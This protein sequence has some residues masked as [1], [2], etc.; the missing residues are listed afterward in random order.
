MQEDKKHEEK[1]VKTLRNG[2]VVV[3][4][5]DTIY[6]IFCRAELPAVVERIRDIKNRD[7]DQA[8]I[9]LCARTDQIAELFDVQKNTL[10]LADQYWPGPVSIILNPKRK[11]AD[12]QGKHE[13][14]AFRIPADADLRRLLEQTGPL[15]APSAN[16]KG[17]EPARNVEEARAYFGDQVDLYVD[18]GTVENVQPSKV[19]K[20]HPDGTEEIFRA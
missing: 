5:S 9:V 8:F 4:P 17:L 7:D 3:M 12:I 15:V 19:I 11:R 14:I 6:G 1:A 16:P 18:G 13:G 10:Q 20:I 2:G